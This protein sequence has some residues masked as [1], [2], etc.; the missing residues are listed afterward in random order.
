MKNWIYIFLRNIVNNITISILILLC[1]VSIY[2]QERQISLSEALEISYAHNEKIKRYTERVQQK[3]YEDKA[4]KGN[5]LPSI[6]LLGGYTYLSDNMEVNTSQ[7]KSSIDDLAGKYGAAFIGSYGESLGLDLTPE[8]AYGTIVNTLGQL[9]AYNLVIDNQQ[10][11]T[12]VLTATQPIY[13]G[14]KIIAAK[15]YAKAELETSE[16]ELKQIKDDIAHELVD[17]YLTVILLKQVINTR[18]QVYDGML[19][20]KAQTERAIELEILPK[21][22]LLRAQVAVADAEKDLNND[23]N[24]LQLAKMALRTTM[25]LSDSVDFKV[26]DSISYQDLYFDF[27]E[28]LNAANANQPIL[29]LI[30]QKEIMATQSHALEKSKFMPNIAA[31]GT[32]NMFREDLPI[33][34][35]KFMIGIQAQLNIFNGF[36]DVNKLKASKHLQEEV[37]NAKAYA[38]QQIKLLV[39]SNYMNTLNQQELY[40]SQLATVKLAKENLRINTRRFEEGLGK[41]I[42]VIDATLLYEKSKIEQLV[43]LDGYYKAIASLYTSI[44]QPE[45]IIPIIS[46]Q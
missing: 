4:A 37:K 25:N 14:G 46:N 1:S 12:A 40:N 31:F 8:A 44:G 29:E 36:K 13:T 45:K 22:I 39:E 24:K 6:N 5:F 11:P 28:L 30:N 9:P 43:A 10:I 18:Q 38:S 3:T 41:S 20:H 16:I 27:N 23:K 35:P 32:Y 19:T 21:H 34:P 7:V 33:V 26:M 2:G 15:K 42:D 17:R